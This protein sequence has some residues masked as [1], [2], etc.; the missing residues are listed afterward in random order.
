MASFE[1]MFRIPRSHVLKAKFHS[2][3]GEVPESWSTW[4]MTT[5]DNSFAQ[6]GAA[7]TRTT[8]AAER[9]IAGRSSTSTASSLRRST[10]CPHEL[11]V[12]QGRRL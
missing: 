3:G 5:E 4:S 6:Y 12:D 11:A 2:Y 10:A 9:A 1:E 8:V 7:R